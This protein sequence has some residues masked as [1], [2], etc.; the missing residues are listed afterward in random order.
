VFVNGKLVGS[1]KDRKP[2]GQSS[3]YLRERVYDLPQELL[4][5]NGVN[6]IEVLVEDMGHIGGIYEGVIGIT[7]K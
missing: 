1:T 7:R 6:T 2:F 3:S 4:I 5:R